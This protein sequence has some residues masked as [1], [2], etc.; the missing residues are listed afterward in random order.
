[1][2]VQQL[3]QSEFAEMLKSADNKTY[4][5]TFDNDAWYEQ[6]TLEEVDYRHK[7]LSLKKISSELLTK[8]AFE[9][10]PSLEPIR[11]RAQS[12]GPVIALV[13]NTKS[14]LF[15]HLLTDTRK[16]MELAKRLVV[17]FGKSLIPKPVVPES[18]SDHCAN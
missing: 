16:E 6:V 13:F 15:Y 2:E 9:A 7:V 11:L 17:F 10:Q 8:K 4:T 14:T 1:M 12:N 5:T 18:P 3:S